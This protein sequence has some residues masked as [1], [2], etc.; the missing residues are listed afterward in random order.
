VFGKIA[1]QEDPS[2]NAHVAIFSSEA[3]QNIPDA[4]CR[5]VSKPG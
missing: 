5:L 1:N 3:P 2:N 4:L